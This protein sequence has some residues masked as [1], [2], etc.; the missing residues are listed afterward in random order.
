MQL[1]FLT[2][3]ILSHLIITPQS[4][5]IPKTKKEIKKVPRIV[6][7]AKPSVAR[8]KLNAQ[9]GFNILSGSAV[10][11]GFQIGR[12]VSSKHSIYLGPEINFMLFSPGSVLNVLLGGWIENHLFY[13]PKKTIDVGL[14]LGSGFSNQRPDWKTTNFVVLMDLSYTQEIDDSLSLRGQL[15][16]G[17]FG[18]KVFGNLNFNAQFGFP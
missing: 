10:V 14:F 17:V 6:I 5:S 4:F 18:G 11:S 15:R 1:R 9:F 12:L 16:P 7:V 8:T 2:V 3:V 13:D